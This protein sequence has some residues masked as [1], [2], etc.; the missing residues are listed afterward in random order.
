MT[1]PD[2]LDVII[3]T[4]QSGQATSYTLA[5][6]LDCPQASVRRDIQKLRREGYIISEPEPGREYYY[7]GY[8][9][10]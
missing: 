8:R 7:G 6:L 1:K 5:G 4:L 9:G 10:D 2:R 3:S